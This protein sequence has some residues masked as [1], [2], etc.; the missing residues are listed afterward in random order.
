MTERV[1]WLVGAFVTLVAV[2]MLA[3][4]PVS[5]EPADLYETWKAEATANGHNTERIRYLRHLAR[6]GDPVPLIHAEFSNVGADPYQAER[7]AWCESK[8]NTW[9]VGAA[10]ERSLF[11]IHPIH[12]NGV[13]ASLGYSWDDIFDPVANINVA[14]ALY[15]RAGSFRSWSCAYLGGW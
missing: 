13:V 6:L 7:I 11:Q 3:V 1:S 4:R 12:R 5:A 2:A 9:A 10:G 8:F 14:V 15:Q